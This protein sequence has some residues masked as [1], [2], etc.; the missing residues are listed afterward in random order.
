MTVNEADESGI[1]PVGERVRVAGR[2]LYLY[3]AGAGAPAV[4]FLPGAG[5]VGLDFLNV[6]RAVAEFTTAVLYDRGGTGWSDRVDLP[7]TASEVATELHSLLEAAAIPGPYL[8]VAHDLGGAY[9]RRFAQLF[10][11]ATA[12]L[13]GLDPFHEDWDA[14][15]PADLHLD[16]T[17]T[18]TP[19]RFQTTLLRVL[20]RPFYRAMFADWPPGIRKPLVEGHVGRAWMV[21][22]ARERRN[23]AAV[24]DELKAG[25]P[26]PDVP[27]TVLAAAGVDS[28]QRRGLTKTMRAELVEAKNAL[29]SAM[30]GAVTVGEYRALPQARHS[31]LHLDASD[32]VVEA[33]R[34]V[35]RRVTS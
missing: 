28:G 25:T 1:P 34:A 23:L 33:V 10:P 21:A 16:Q 4:V 9:A 26:F 19:G 5:G 15:M 31:T 29:Y 17:P 20:S 14:H 8:L 27:V 30:T 13:V 22:G 2:H 24:R 32:A 3:R 35:H 18:V 6:H 7:R 12:G 11:E